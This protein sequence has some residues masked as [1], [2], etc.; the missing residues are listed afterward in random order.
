[1]VLGIGYRVMAYRFAFSER[2][3]CL[4]VKEGG[5]KDVLQMS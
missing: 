3:V 5:G 1:M 4:G 2:V